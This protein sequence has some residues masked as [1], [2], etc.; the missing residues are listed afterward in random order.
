MKKIKDR[1]ISEKIS[2]Y[3]YSISGRPRSLQVNQLVGFLSISL[4]ISL[5]LASS[6]LYIETGSR[7]YR[8]K[9]S[10]AALLQKCEKLEAE[11]KTLKSELDSLSTELSSAENELDKI[12]E[13][14][15]QLEQSQF[16]KSINR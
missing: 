14:K 7:Y 1:L 3:F 10:N 15:N 9:Q 8:L 5:L 2:I 13:Y 12:I 6:L 4:L 11:N 16:I